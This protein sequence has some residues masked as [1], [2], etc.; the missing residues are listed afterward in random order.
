MS[1]YEY[2]HM[3]GPVLPDFLVVYSSNPLEKQLAIEVAQNNFLK[4]QLNA[5]APLNSSDGR[6]VRTSAFGAVDSGLIPS[7]I[8]SMTIKLAFTASLVDAQH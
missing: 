2:R 7:Q 3:T 1:H 6:A 4:K 8:K 5:R